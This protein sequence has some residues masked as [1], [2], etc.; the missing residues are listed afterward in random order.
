MFWRAPEKS[1]KY[2]LQL[3]KGSI[4]MATVQSTVNV[5]WVASTLMT[6]IDSRGTP[7]VIGTWPE[8][9]PQ[10]TGMKASDLL[11]LAA[12]SCSTYDLASILR[13]QREPLISLE[14]HCTGEQESEPPHTFTGIHLRYVIQGRINPEK[15]AKAIRLSEEK[16]CSVT[17]TLRKAVKITSEFEILE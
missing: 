12:A 3:L 1:G 11:L 5:K 10:W 6:G 17:N 4:S 9:N 7:I 14:A 16:Y 13:K 8:Q 15:V 2:N